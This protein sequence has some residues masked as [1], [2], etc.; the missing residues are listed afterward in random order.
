[1]YFA[2][3]LFLSYSIIEIEWS[4]FFYCINIR[5]F[6]MLIHMNFL[7]FATNEEITLIEFLFAFFN[8]THYS[9]STPSTSKCIEFIFPSS[10]PIPFKTICEPNALSDWKIVTK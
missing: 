5:F 1:M 7:C 2:N 4:V 3:L 8:Q 10:I 6:K 9:I